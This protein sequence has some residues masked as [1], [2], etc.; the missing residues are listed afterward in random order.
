MD[1]QWAAKMDVECQVDMLGCM[2]CRRTARLVQ[3]RLETFDRRT[4]HSIDD[5]THRPSQ[6]Q[7]FREVPKLTGMVY[8]TETRCGSCRRRQTQN[9][10]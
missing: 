9:L 8:H 3:T 2:L 1:G 7:A 5:P 10:R 4:M 6:Q